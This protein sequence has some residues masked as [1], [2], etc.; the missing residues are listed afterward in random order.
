[1]DD[2][3]EIS[4]GVLSS[5]QLH[6]LC[7]GENPL[8]DGWNDLAIQIQPNGFDLRIDS[9]ARHVGAGTVA[10]DNAHRVLPELEAIAPD[11]NGFFDLT[12]GVYH[13]TYFET[14]RIPANL[15]ALGRARS[16]LQRSG[17]TIH[18]A[19]WDAGYHGR[20]TSLLSV[21]NPDGFRVERGARVMQ[22]V[23][24]GLANET[25]NTYQGRYQ[26]ENLKPAP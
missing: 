6:H 5:E 16:S 15:M 10:I 13:I 26:G 25:A 7:T 12:P 3:I 18:T 20:S 11:A 21:L 2:R 17:A 9:V 4:A 19:V 1:M 14:V 24:F 23:F 22:L 8:V